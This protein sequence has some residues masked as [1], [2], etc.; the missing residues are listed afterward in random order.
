MTAV[1][2]DDIRALIADLPPSGEPKLEPSPKLGRLGELAAWLSCWRQGP[3]P[4]GS[5][6]PRIH[7]PI[8]A[9]YAGTHQ[10]ARHSRK[11]S[12]P[13]GVRARLE[14]V[15]AGAAAVNSLAQAQG[16]GLE[17][18]DLAIDRP[19]PDILEHAALSE[20]ECAATMAF[21]MEALAKQPD[22]L[23]LGEITAGGR[24]A[25]A[26]LALLLF[27]GEAG[28]WIEG[29]EGDESVVAR[30]AE[31]ARGQ[32]GRSTDPLEALRQV[33]GREIAAL[34]GAILA[35]R[36]QSVPVLLGGYGAAMA[37]AVLQKIDP[38]A[39]EHVLAGDAA[40]YRAASEE[41]GLSPLIDY[42]IVAG[43]GL[44]ALAALPM[45]KLACEAAG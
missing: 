33:G 40:S 35:A 1:P 38:R 41:I 7:R 15:A 32:M 3:N 11:A 34:A 19:V 5:G 45:L 39:V 8:L 29:G 25:A 13:D 43:E 24:I 16:A 20:R 12:T 4:G 30:A 14:A 9:L 22:L 21:G 42:G 6:A 27:G 18:F 28:E 36:T 23:L 10:V 2:F 26:A 31:R 37:A 44:S 17:A